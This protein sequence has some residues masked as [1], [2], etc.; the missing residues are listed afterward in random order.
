[1]SAT[2]WP[3]ATANMVPSARCTTSPNPSSRGPAARSSSPIR[4]RGSSP[5]TTTTG[6]TQRNAPSSNS[7]QPPT[8]HATSTPTPSTGST[9]GPVSAT[10]GSV[11][12]C[13]GTTSSSS[14]RYRTRRS[15]WPTTPSP[16]ACRRFQSKISI[17][18]S[19]TRC[20]TAR[21]PSRAAP[22]SAHS[23]SARSGSTGTRSPSG[24][25]RTT[26]SRITSPSFCTTT[27]NCSTRPSGPRESRS[28]VWAYWRA[29]RCPP[30]RATSSCLARQSRSMARTRFAS[31][32]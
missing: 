19:S 10:T 14:S 6:P 11:L 30:R 15:T 21:T 12:G 22:T 3:Q 28:W 29:R 32:C 2:N 20:S 23:T 25:P 5:T 7:I 13:R 31:S 24:S 9:N 16:I 18:S 27:P 4:I 26:S 8:T 17:E 1:M